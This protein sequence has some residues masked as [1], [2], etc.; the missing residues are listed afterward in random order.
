MTLPEEW[1]RAPLYRETFARLHCPA[2]LA[3][4]RPARR[5]RRPAP[6][7][8]ALCAVVLAAC[9]A[10]AAGGAA[11]RALQPEEL[12]GFG[13]SGFCAVLD[14]P[15]TPQAELP[16][17][18]QQQAE[19]LHRVDTLPECIQKS[20]SAAQDPAG[21]WV[22]VETDAPRSES[23]AAGEALLLFDDW[24]QAA[25]LLGWEVEPPAAAA[26]MNPVVRSTLA[27][28]GEAGRGRAM[29]RLQGDAASAALDRVSL[30]ESWSSG[31]GML[32]VSVSELVGEGKSGALTAELRFTKGNDAWQVQDYELPGGAKATLAVPE[33]A[34]PNGLWA[35]FSR[36]G[37]AYAVAW[38]PA[39]GT[40]QAQALAQLQGILDGF[41]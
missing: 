10:V 22:T 18:V 11:L 19:N 34:S 5:P 38:T 4:P 40:T 25:D 41:A 33:T 21:A 9:G 23:Y 28:D 24:Q 20:D 39:G 3:A 17:A 15:L 32:T 29:V 12:A 36:D 31:A 30:E 14:L 27:A 8:A 37:R 6:V 26:E 7:P 16:A 35:F 13:Q 2:A 1:G